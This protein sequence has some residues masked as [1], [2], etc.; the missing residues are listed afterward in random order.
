MA[1]GQGG[2][3]KDDKVG[4]C[5]I[6]DVMLDYFV[7]P[8]KNIFC[9]SNCSTVTIYNSTCEMYSVIFLNLTV[10]VKTVLKHIKSISLA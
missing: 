10:K 9:L 5:H 3:H 8:K 2:R 7:I 4:P 1:H 6:R